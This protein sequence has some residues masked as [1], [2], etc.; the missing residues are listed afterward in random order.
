[1]LYKEHIFP[2]SLANMPKT[3]RTHTHHTLMRSQQNPDLVIIFNLNVY[4]DISTITYLYIQYVGVLMGKKTFI[5]WI[6]GHVR[7]I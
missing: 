6:S 2:V 4:K 1:M 3:P 7:C 5:L